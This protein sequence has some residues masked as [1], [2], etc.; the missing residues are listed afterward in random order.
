[1]TGPARIG[2]SAATSVTSDVMPAPAPIGSIQ[3]TPSATT[4]ANASAM[5]S[6][7]A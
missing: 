2:S 5:H 7:P 4:S 3:P 1:M 6:Q